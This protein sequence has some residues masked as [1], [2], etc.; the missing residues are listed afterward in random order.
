MNHGLSLLHCSGYKWRGQSGEMVEILGQSEHQ[1]GRQASDWR[2]SSSQQKGNSSTS[3]GI[4]THKWIC[5]CN[6]CLWFKTND[7]STCSWKRFAQ[8]HSNKNI[9]LCVELLQELSSIRTLTVKTFKIVVVLSRS[10]Q[11]K[12]HWWFFPRGIYLGQTRWIYAQTNHHLCTGTLLCRSG[13]L[14]VK[15]RS[16]SQ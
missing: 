5:L 8:Q 4:R 1:E 12:H 3:R 10:T 13:R 15:L 2:G 9:F 6:I 7:E 14:H 16:K 11:G